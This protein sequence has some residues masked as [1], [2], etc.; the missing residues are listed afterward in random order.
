VGTSAATNRASIVASFASSAGSADPVPSPKLPLLSVLRRMEVPGSPARPFCRR[1]VSLPKR[2]WQVSLPLEQVVTEAGLRAAV[3]YFPD[4]GGEPRAW[5][6]RAPAPAT[7]RTTTPAQH[8]RRG[9]S[10]GRSR[11]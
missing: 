1:A 10:R 7:P 8:V 11:A 6:G 4:S 2:K 3:M 9:D 5:G